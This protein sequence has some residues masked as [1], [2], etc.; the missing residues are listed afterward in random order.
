[1]NDTLPSVGKRLKELLMSRS[2]NDRL[3]MGC[4]MFDDAKAMLRAGLRADSPRANDR[5]MRRM[6]FV[7]LY[8]NDF[9]PVK[10]EEILK[11]I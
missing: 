9:S 2:G 8:G 6:L 1:M 10:L 4:A 11:G 7:R 3:A 5:E